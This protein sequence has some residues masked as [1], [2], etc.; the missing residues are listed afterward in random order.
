MDIPAS[1]FKVS[2]NKAMAF[3]YKTDDVDE[4][5]TQAIQHIKDLQEENDTLLEKMGVLASNLEKYRDEEDSLR[6]ALVGAQKLGDSI[7]RD[8]RGKAEAILRDAT[9][10]A[11]KVTQDAALELERSQ[12]ELEHVQSETTNF[13]EKLFSLYRSHLDLINNIPSNKDI[14]EKHRN[15]PPPP[16]P[17]TPPPAPKKPVA[18]EEYEQEDD[19]YDEQYDPQYS[20][21][22]QTRAKPARQPE[23]RYE[24]PPYN[25]PSYDEQ[26]YE[27]PYEEPYEDEPYEEATQSHGEVYDFPTEQAKPDD[28]EDSYDYAQTDTPEPEP[29]PEPE[30]IDSFVVRRQTVPPD[31]DVTTAFKT[32]TKPA[33]EHKRAKSSIFEPFPMVQME[34]FEGESEEHED[35]EFF[36][37]TKNLRSVDLNRIPYFDDEDEE[38]DDFGAQASS[39]SKHRVSKK[40]GELKFGDSFN[41]ADD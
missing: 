8:C 34:F 11:D 41:L 12:Y 18:E 2:F 21:P 28:F 22:Q 40:F 29:Q 23:N 37:D 26:P 13:K 5:V 17:Q 7:L 35:D 24:E 9:A 16:P 15:S 6:S 10:R 4:F 30:P 25:E 27:E 39:R 31:E 19:G 32:R 3:G 1:F 38:E 14:V 36:E 33:V 20:E